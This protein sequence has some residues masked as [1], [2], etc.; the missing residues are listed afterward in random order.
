[1]KK[2]RRRDKNHDDMTIVRSGEPVTGLLEA[3]A[4]LRGRLVHT[5]ELLDGRDFLF[6]GPP[7]LLRSALTRIV[8][9]EHRVPGGLQCVFT[10]IDTFFLLRIQGPEERQK[11]IGSYFS[12]PP[13]A[14]Q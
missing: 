10:Q 8:E 14:P 7:S 9:A 2:I 1:M 13:I 3:M 4:Q 6:S 12:P 11:E 5:R